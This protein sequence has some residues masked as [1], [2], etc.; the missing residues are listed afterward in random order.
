MLVEGQPESAPLGDTM[1]AP[2]EPVP[3]DEPVRPSVAAV[4]ETAANTELLASLSRG[5]DGVE[6]ATDTMD[7]V[8]GV[9]APSPDINLELTSALDWGVND[10]LAP[11]QTPVV[12][13]KVCMP[14]RCSVL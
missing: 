1:D 11:V 14:T 10:T 6:P 5:E 12:P 4:P 13:A 3:V 7:G 8:P 2:A 9:A